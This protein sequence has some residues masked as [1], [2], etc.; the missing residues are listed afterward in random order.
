MSSS[1]LA[2][3]MPETA[4]DSTDGAPAFLAAG[5][6]SVGRAGAVVGRLAGGGLFCSSSPPKPES[7]LESDGLGSGVGGLRH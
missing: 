1:A 7:C 4:A 6:A 3:I 5:V 2:V